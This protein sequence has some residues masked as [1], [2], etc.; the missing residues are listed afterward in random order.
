MVLVVVVDLLTELELDGLLVDDLVELLWP[1]GAPSANALQA[2]LSKLR[3]AIAPVDVVLG[4]GRYTLRGEVDTDLDDLERFHA[5]GDAQAIEALHWPEEFDLRDAALRR[6]ATARH[7]GL[8]DSLRL[9]RLF[10]RARIHQ[11]HL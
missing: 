11:D 7:G 5:L 1:D 10:Y 8:C 4:R 9:V 6:L 2:V 3:K